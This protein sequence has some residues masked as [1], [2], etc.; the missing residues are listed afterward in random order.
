MNPLAIAAIAIS[1]IQALLAL[2][3]P[4]AFSLMVG[5]GGAL[6]GSWRVLLRSV[7]GGKGASAGSVWPVV[8]GSAWITPMRPGNGAAGRSAVVGLDLGRGAVL[9]A[10]AGQGAVRSAPQS[11]SWPRG[12]SILPRMFVS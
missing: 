1:V 12:G 10:D 7:T 3:V 4:M 8:R 9:A 2:F 11:R 6:G 5:G